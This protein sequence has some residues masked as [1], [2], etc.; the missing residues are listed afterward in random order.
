MSHTDAYTY[1]LER[2]R[3]NEIKGKRDSAPCRGVWMTHIDVSEK[4]L[5]VDYAYMYLL[6]I[7]I[8]RGRQF[9]SASHRKSLRKEGKV[10]YTKEEGRAKRSRSKEGSLAGLV[11]KRKQRK[12]FCP[13]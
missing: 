8:E 10:S 11:D 6:F 5:Q 4:E 13:D 12:A 1:V 2:E 3:K 7:S 9:L